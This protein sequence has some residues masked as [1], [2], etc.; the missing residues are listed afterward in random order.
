MFLLTLILII[1]C[2]FV[3]LHVLKKTASGRVYVISIEGNIGSGKS[4][5]V[6]KIKEC[7]KYHVLQEPVDVWKSITD[8]DGNNILS[9]YYKN[10][11]RYAY[12]FQ[13]FAFITR[14]KELQD[15]I[16]KVERKRNL[17]KDEYIIVERS[18]FSDKNVFAKKLYN[19]KLISNLEYELY[20]YWFHK[21]KSHVFVSAYIYLKVEPEISLK[22]VIKRSR[23]EEKNSIPIDYLKSLDY[24]HNKWLENTENKV[25][26]INGNDEFEN[27]KFTFNKIYKQINYFVKNI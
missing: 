11:K 12:T 27:D 20:N 1:N 16:E 8:K 4:T 22:R 7:K 21:L 5:L 14:I 25:L 2:F 9:Q 10:Q 23:N 24:Y 19:D 3:F 26:V 15:L 6:K 18:I 17:F 13:N